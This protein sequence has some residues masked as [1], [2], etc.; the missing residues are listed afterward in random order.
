MI[1]RAAHVRSISTTSS[2]LQYQHV[3]I[4]YFL[5]ELSMSQRD[6]LS[7]CVCLCESYYDYMSLQRQNLAVHPSEN[8]HSYFITFITDGHNPETLSFDALTLIS[9]WQTAATVELW[10]VEKTHFSQAEL[11]MHRNNI[12]I[13][14]SMISMNSLLQCVKYTMIIEGSLII[15]FVGRFIVV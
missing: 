8:E 5:N 3:I 6:T 15:L 7:H 14:I 2:L 10:H 13:P 4:F 1:V 12:W 11:R 9:R